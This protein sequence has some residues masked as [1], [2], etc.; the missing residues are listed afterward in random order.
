MLY[1]APGVHRVRRGDVLFAEGMQQII[2]EIAC[3]RFFQLLI[4]Q[5]LKVGGL[6]RKPD[7]HLVREQEGFARVASHEGFP[8]KKL[9]FIIV[10]PIRGVEICEACR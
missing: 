10:V 1:E 4:E 3:A 5:A 8:H 6:L 2:V 7:R 9:G